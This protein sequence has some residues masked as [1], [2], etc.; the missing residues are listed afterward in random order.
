MACDGCGQLASSEHIA[1][2]LRRLECS[3]RYRPIH[4][5][6]LLLGGVSPVCDAEYLY[7]GKFEGQ[8]GSLLEAAG[9]SSAGKSFEVV[10][11]EFQRAGLFLSYLL[12]CPLEGEGTGQPSEESLLFQRVPVTVARIRKS[13]KP[14]RI[15]LI[16][17]MLGPLVSKLNSAEVRCPVLL[18]NG[19]P[20]SL[21]SSASA[22]GP[23][24]IREALATAEAVK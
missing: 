21:D 13:L 3:S 1:R 4:I 2:R 14:K 22:G 9:I 17:E 24:R 15:V 10:L 6:T 12:E 8:A 7:T 16:S 20:F 5:G 19:R 11:N 18:D 23:Q